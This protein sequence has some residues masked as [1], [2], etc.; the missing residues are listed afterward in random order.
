[1]EILLYG[2]IGDPDAGLDAATVVSQISSVAG[3]PLTVRINSQ[4]GLVFDG[5]AIL[6]ALQQHDGAVT[7]QIDGLAASMAS[8]IAMAGDEIV[9]SDSALM[10]IH[11]PEDGAYGDAPAMR[12]AA[13][14][15]DKIRDQIVSIYAARTGLDA[16]ALNAMLAAET[17]MTAEEALNLDFITA[18][19]VSM[20]MAAC[21]I[22][23]FGFRK[24]PDHPLIAIAKR[25]PAAAAVIQPP[26]EKAMP[27]GTTA[28][29][30]TSAEVITA[31]GIT[32][33][34]I[35]N[36][37]NTAASTAAAAAIVAERARAST[38][39][40]EVTRARID[41]AFADMLV[42]EGVSIDVA[43]TRIIDHIATNAPTITN[44]G[45][46]TIP[47]A[48]FAARAEAMSIAILNRANPRNQLNE[49]SRAFAGR[50]LIVLA[51]DWLDSTGIN[52]RMLNDVEVA[53]AA[54]RHRGPVNAGLHTT[55]DFPAILGNTVGRTLRRAYELAP[56]TFPAFCRQAS[57]PDF[58][59]V[60]RVALSDISQMQPVA[61]GGEYQYAT[62][63]DSAEQ[64]LVG[65]W[66]QIISLS[67]ETII[68]DDLSAFDRLPTAMGQ[69]ASQI[70]SDIVYA[71]LTGNP[72]MADGN[73][74][75]SAAHGN[76]AAATAAISIASLGA[77][78]LAMR[79]Q[80][81]PK[82]RPL[83]VVPAN[84]VVGAVNEGLANQYT[85]ANYVATKN[86]DINPE[87]NRSLS[88][89]VEPRIIDDRWFM[90]ADPN[91]IAID[92]IEYA[93]L[94]GAEGVMIEQRQGF[95]VDGVDIKARLVFGAKAIDWRGLYSVPHS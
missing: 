85:S 91:A 35:T 87:Y 17:W 21:D 52:T 44:F 12:S 43:R 90:A 18:I 40:A 72:N 70:E 73:P 13:D 25:S 58:R 57:V 95:E 1:M 49:D 55:S 63:G 71:I 11:N 64:Y 7:I 47:A 4:G 93:Y 32:A 28:A 33:A 9:M 15:L 14:R 82:G 31:V 77:G 94:A 62:I 16:G 60:S 8:V 84:L 92:T 54:F 3:Q 66:G 45:P 74:L 20:R 69:E 39:R 56:K 86:T 68:N 79:T 34:D 80:K 76:L 27:E 19:G 89:T 75:F 61:Q 50:R 42:N 29:E 67:W 2:I 88:V 41:A 78:R 22:T 26:K 5:L 83:S 81:A 38:I 53:Q 10:M 6:N 65:K 48:Q 30:I 36:A 51:R 24:A 23:A 59:P 37:A 46:A